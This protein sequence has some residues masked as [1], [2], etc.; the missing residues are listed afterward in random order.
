[1]L[2][3]RIITA[4]VLL[5]LLVASLLTSTRAEPLPFF[6]LM[7]VM[8]TAASWEWMRMNG[9]PLRHQITGPAVVALLCLGMMAVGW[10]LPVW[11]WPWLGVLW[12]IL[13]AAG[14]VLGPRHWL[15]VPLRWRWS[16]GCGALFVLW[17]AL[18][19]SYV[20]G[21]NFLFS[22]LALI[23]VADTAAYFGGKRFGRFRLA[24]SISPGKTWEGAFFGLLG[25]LCLAGIWVWID[26]WLLGA[27]GEM[28]V[29]AA[30]LSQ[31]MAGAADSGAFETSVINVHSLFSVIQASWDWQGLVYAVIALTVM[32]IAGDLLESLVKRAVQVKDSSALLPGHG[33]VL[34][35]IDAWLPVLPFA[36]ALMWLTGNL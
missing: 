17:C 20:L 31:M 22:V 12:L 18:A 11:V 13:A 24:P 30:Q 28:P 33:G 6:T 35:R 15:S 8:V 14:L 23:W 34:D 3:H 25:V 32:S 1:M 5:V 26:G 27:V 21:L 4:V 19:Q 2:K 7:A 10:L 16:L 9:A 36:L 29:D